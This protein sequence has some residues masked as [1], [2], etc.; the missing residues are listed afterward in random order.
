MISEIAARTN[1]LALNA[2]IEA[3]R[4]GDAGKGFAVVASEVKQLA[5][6]TARSTAEIAQHIDAVRAA[7]GASVIAVTDIERTI[8]DINAVAVAIAAAVEEQGAATS[9]IAHNV[10]ETAA[11]A[12]DMTDR[13]GEVSEEAG[14]TGRHAATV[15]EH[16][17]ALHLSVGSLRQSVIRVVRTATPDVDRRKLP[18]Y[19]V[20]QSC[21]VSSERHGRQTAHLI[22]L[23]TGGASLGDCPTLR[24]RDAARLR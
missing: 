20:G 21:I 1:L 4:A 6:Q 11:A 7:T 19:E 9:D 8:G 10:A 2:T 22:E 24:P 17:E 5:T 12:R 16:T 18:R 13:I 14:R 3:A 15:L 23:S